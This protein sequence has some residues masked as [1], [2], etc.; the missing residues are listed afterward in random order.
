M[1]TPNESTDLVLPEV[2]V[3]DMSRYGDEAFSEVAKA[4]SFLPYL[5]LFGSNSNAVK[6]GLIPMAHYGL[7]KSKDD[8]T[9]L[10]SEVD[11][12][13]LAWRPKAIDFGSD[14]PVSFYDPKHPEFQRIAQQSNIQDSECQAGPEFLLYVPKTKQYVT[15]LMGGKTAKNEAGKVRLLIGKKMNLSARFIEK[16]KWGWHGPVAKP[17]SAPI[18]DAPPM[19]KMREEIE[20]FLNPPEAQV[21]VASD[22]NKPADGAAAEGDRPR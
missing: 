21:E 16:G 11:C 2:A 6:R 3:A 4:S 8:I 5:G 19:E 10:G 20:R 1:S 12:F 9:D 18:G 22:V 17:Q 15:Y 7:R 13:V 14:T